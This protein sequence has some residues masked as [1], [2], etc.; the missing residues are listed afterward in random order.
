MRSS[1]Q[2][3]AAAAACSLALAA[4]GG[5]PPGDATSPADPDDRTPEQRSPTP[6]PATAI[7]DDFPLSAG[8]AGPA[9]TIPTSRSGTGLR[10]LEL[11]GTSPLRGLGT[12]DRMV[13]DNSGG[14][15]LDARELVLLGSP[16]EAD[17]VA[18]SFADLSTGC[19]RPA[20]GGGVETTT[21]VRASAF[22]AAPTAVLVQ[23]YVVDGEPGPG[24]LV[25]HVVPV[26]AA[27]LVTQ[28]YG[29]WP[30]VSEGVARTTE[31]LAEVVDAM[32]VFADDAAD[33]AA[34]GTRGVGPVARG[35]GAWAILDGDASDGSPSTSG[36]STV[37]VRV[38]RA[39][40]V[41]RHGG[42]AGCPDG[43]GPVRVE[44]RGSQAARSIT[45]M[46]QL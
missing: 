44:A 37:V 24:H 13:A 6:R 38:G 30:D 43:D 3:L 17:L 46:C 23:G 45:Q 39:V 36:G 41:V 5:Q 29:E 7:P 1:T 33:A 15:A 31:P 34:A 12:R 4:C 10:S 16:D 27:L 2:R 40:Q 11:C 21:E 25:V 35:G 8:M 22:G 28:T 9:D 20:P 19:D 14:E 18:Q 32:V 42:H 26:G